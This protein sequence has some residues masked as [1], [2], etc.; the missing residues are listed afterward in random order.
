MKSQSEKKPL[1]QRAFDRLPD[2]IIEQ[3]DAHPSRNPEC[4][5][6]RRSTTCA[7]PLRGA[8]LTSMP[9]QNPPDHGPELVRLAH[10]TQ[11]HLAPRLPA[12][13]PLCTP[14]RSVPVL[15]CKPRLHPA[16]DQLAGWP[17]P[18]TTSVRPRSQAEPL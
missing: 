16:A 7:S 5:L 3:Y 17:A 2:E 12:G 4:C 10:L 8:L 15:R 14:P 6:T 11:L 9:S 1:V 13:R 18:F